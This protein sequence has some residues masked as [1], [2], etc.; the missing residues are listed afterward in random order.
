MDA[1]IEIDKFNI[2]EDEVFETQRYIDATYPPEVPTL[3]IEVYN[4]LM[5]YKDRAMEYI[6]GTTIYP[7]GFNLIYL[8]KLFRRKLNLEIYPFEFAV[9]YLENKIKEE[10][11]KK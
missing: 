1:R 6:T 4:F 9:E 8:N 5:K 3:S 10:F 2:S 7:K 11:N